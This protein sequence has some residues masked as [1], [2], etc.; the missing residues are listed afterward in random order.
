M[1]VMINR[2]RRREKHMVEDLEVEKKI[3]NRS[4]R[5]T[6]EKERRALFWGLL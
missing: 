5:N 1:N 6:K 3:V 2:R 4:I